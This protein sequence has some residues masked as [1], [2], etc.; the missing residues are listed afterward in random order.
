MTT[1]TD[2]AIPTVIHTPP[3]SMT[4]CQRGLIVTKTELRIVTPTPTS[5]D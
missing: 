1:V 4:H 5:H 2:I 3:V